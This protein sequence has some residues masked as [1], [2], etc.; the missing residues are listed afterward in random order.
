[1]RPI[2]F[3]F[4]PSNPLFEEI[5]GII[6][7]GIFSHRW[8]LLSA[9]HKAGELLVKFNLTADEA[10]KVLRHRKKD[11]HYAI[12]LYK[13]YPDINSVP[14]GKNVSWYKITKLLPP[15]EDKDKVK[16]AK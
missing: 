3:Y 8:E 1:M 15:Y 12:E 5:D 7:E 14:D 16:K 6:T 11:I 9:Y 13:K 10:C 4:H 2:K